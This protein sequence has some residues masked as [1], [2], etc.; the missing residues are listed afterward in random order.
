MLLFREEMKNDKR[1]KQRKRNARESMSVK[2]DITIS[3]FTDYK[4]P[5]TCKASWYSFFF[6]KYM[7]LSF[8]IHYKACEDNSWK[9]RIE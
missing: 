4:V 5:V 2:M 6:V 9:S 8:I 1:G 3:F 7:R